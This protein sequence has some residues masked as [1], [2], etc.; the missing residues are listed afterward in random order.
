MAEGDTIRAKEVLTLAHNA[1]L[2]DVVPHT[3]T[4]IPLIVRYT[5][6]AS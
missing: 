3:F 5:M 6:Q 4:S 1:I 2:E